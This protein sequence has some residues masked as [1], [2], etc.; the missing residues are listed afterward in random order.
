M[1]IGDL[2][3]PNA[4]PLVSL[5]KLD[6]MLVDFDVDEQALSRR[7]EQNQQR[8]AQGL[9]PMEFTPRLKLVTGDLYEHVGVIDYANNRINPST[10]TISGDR[11]VSQPRQPALP[12]PVCAHPGAA[13]RARNSAC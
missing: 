6:P 11:P 5:V 13:W 4:G 8:E 12:G 2:V 1:S 9:P 7:L 10:G 3:D